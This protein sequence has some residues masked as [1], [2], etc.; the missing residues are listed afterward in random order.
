MLSANL[1]SPGADEVR[2]NC[3]NDLLNQDFMPGSL[4]FKPPPEHTAAC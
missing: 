4:N 3:F 1:V 2:S